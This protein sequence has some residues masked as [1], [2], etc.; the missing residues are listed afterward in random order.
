MPEFK[1]NLSKDQKK[2]YLQALSY[3]LSIGENPVNDKYIIDQANDIDF[4][5]DNNPIAKVKNI[6]KLIKELKAISDLRIKR[7]I[8]REMILLAISDHELQDT[9]IETIFIIGSQIGI[10]DEKINDFF[11]WA[12]KGLEWQIEGSKLVEEDI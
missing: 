1:S 6:D 9:E 11:L 2:L 12:A 10:A 7:L 3:V 5:L 8:L 4:D